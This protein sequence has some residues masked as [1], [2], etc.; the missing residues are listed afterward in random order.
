MIATQLLVIGQVQ[1]QCAKTVAAVN[2]IA[3][4]TSMAMAI[5]M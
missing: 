2:L 4:K 1:R 3:L 5:S